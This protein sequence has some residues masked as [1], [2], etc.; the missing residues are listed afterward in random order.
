M[1]MAARATDPGPGAVFAWIIDNC[2]ITYR[3]RS[4]PAESATA[5]MIRGFRA[6]M[7]GF[8]SRK[9]NQL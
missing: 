2:M 4:A 8:A 9:T 1:S 7:A 3:W 6:A 5:E